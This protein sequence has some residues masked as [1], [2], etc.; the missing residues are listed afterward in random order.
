MKD[1]GDS[2]PLSPHDY[3]VMHFQNRLKREVRKLDIGRWYLPGRHYATASTVLRIRGEEVPATEISVGIGKRR[4][5]FIF[6]DC[7]QTS[8]YKNGELAGRKLKGDE[9]LNA[10]RWLIG[11]T[12]EE[13]SDEG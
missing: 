4:L 2:E 13:P 8:W 7:R 5:E 9:L 11:E 6:R 3:A 10:C 12:D 1:R